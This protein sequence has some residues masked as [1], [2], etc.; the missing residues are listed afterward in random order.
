[1]IRSTH[2]SSCAALVRSLLTLRKERRS[3]VLTVQT[4][5]VKTFVYL[6]Q[7]TPVFAEEGTH[8]ET[9]GRLLVRQGR[10]TQAQY[11]EVLGKMTDALVINEQLRFGEVCVELGYLSEDQ[12]AKALADQVR[13]KIVRV[14]QRAD[15]TWSFEES[16]SALEEIGR[17]PMTIESLVLDA[18]R[19]IDDEQKIELGLGAALDKHMK[20][21]V[22]I[23]PLVT[24]A[25]DLKDDEE[26]FV[27][28]L[29]GKTTLRETLKTKDANDVDAK[30]IT[31]ALLLTRALQPV[32]AAP[33][34]TPDKPF[35]PMKLPPQVAP[36]IARPVT[37]PHPI[38][39]VAVAAPPKVVKKPAVTKASAI[40]RALESQRVKAEPTRTPTS[41]HEAKL[42]GERIFQEGLDHVRAGRYAQAAPRLEQASRLFPKSDEYR[43]YAKWTSIRGRG[44]AAHAME[45]H[46]LRKIAT[47]A[48]KA[49]PNFGFGY[50]VL[51]ELTY[52]EGDP[53]NAFR[54]LV[55]AVKLDPTNLEATRLV[56][57]VERVVDPKK[58]ASIRQSETDE[59]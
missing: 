55:R 33:I 28:R 1:M 6:D 21:D 35:S 42:L 52:D 30:A 8:G 16:A 49:D 32:A 34:A 31:T 44:E 43:L 57:V 41:E 58:R 56:R 5:A 25:F 38:Q 3:G 50:F 13:W 23:V 29:D 53:T 47:S 24:G 59:K 18:V 22:G 54:Y 20:V 2:V 9:L 48:V 4:D 27:K 19:W 14:F 46:E 40:L 11:V 10:L 51:G 45:R 17:F 26:R 37:P 7:G 39:P 12:V 36:V 15:A